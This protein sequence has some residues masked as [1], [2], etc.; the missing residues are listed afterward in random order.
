[1]QSIRDPVEHLNLFV[2]SM[3]AKQSL[4]NRCTSIEISIRD[5]MYCPMNIDGPIWSRWRALEL[6]CLTLPKSTTPRQKTLHLIPNELSISSYYEIEIHT[7]CLGS[8]EVTA[9]CEQY[10]R[11][12]EYQRQ[13]I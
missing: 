7:L 12:A 2:I 13:Q 4:C 11:G 8:K 5:R 9:L 3:I 1:M 10:L 6:R